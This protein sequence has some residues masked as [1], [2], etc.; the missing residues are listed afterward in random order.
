MQ[1]ATG[2]VRSR[3]TRSICRDRSSPRLST[4]LRATV[5]RFGFPIRTAVTCGQFSGRDGGGGGGRVGVL[6]EYL[7]VGATAF[8]PAQEQ[9][10]TAPTAGV[11]AEPDFNMPSLGTILK[12]PVP[13]PIVLGAAEGQLGYAQNHR[14]TSR[15]RVSARGSSHPCGCVQRLWERYLQSGAC[16]GSDRA[17]QK[18]REQ[19]GKGII[20]AAK[21]GERDQRRLCE[22][23]LLHVA[24]LARRDASR[25]EP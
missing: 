11:F 17:M 2:T 22:D 1:P 5:S 12:P 4:D 25:N 9:C 19:L 15:R 20:E 23:A 14:Y 13:A 7:W 18:A 21:R 3:R 8:N 24:Q 10:V 6:G 16:F